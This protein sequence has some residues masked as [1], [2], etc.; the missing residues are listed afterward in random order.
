MTYRVIPDPEVSGLSSLSI[1]MA[2]VS[3]PGADVKRFVKQISYA[4]KTE[5]VY[6]AAVAKI[7]AAALSS[8]KSNDSQDNW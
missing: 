4:S 6:P 2:I 1:S 8:Y 3:N 7:S 5:S